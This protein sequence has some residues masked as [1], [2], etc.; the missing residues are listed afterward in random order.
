MRALCVGRHQFLSDHLSL[1][2]HDFG[3]ETESAVGLG[4]AIESVRRRRPDLILC[5]YDLLATV[6]PEQWER[7]EVMAGTPVVAV[8]LTRRPNEVHL[9][10]VRGLTGFLYLPTLTRDNALQIL[11]SIRRPV[12]EHYGSSLDRERSTAAN[13]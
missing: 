6:P 7:D 2:F 5:D 8:S 3:L 9:M 13:P 10:E 12:R 4:G 11:G 1:I